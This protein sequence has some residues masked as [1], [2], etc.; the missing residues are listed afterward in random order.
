MLLDS[1]NIISLKTLGINM[2]LHSSL[3]TQFILIFYHN[4]SI[5]HSSSN[6]FITP[7]FITILFTWFQYL[8]SIITI[9]ISIVIIVVVVFI[10]NC[11]YYLFVT[12]VLITILVIITAIWF[13]NIFC[14]SCH[15]ISPFATSS[16]FWLSYYNFLS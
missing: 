5:N 12:L 3:L 6:K 2:I 10:T 15:E 1:F 16:C 4:D 8:L 13:D 11:Y 9:F 14:K 7:I